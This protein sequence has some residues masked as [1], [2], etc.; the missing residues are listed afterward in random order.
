M[1]VSAIISEYN[2]FH[3]GHAYHIEETRKSGATHIVAIMS[4]NFVQRGDFAIISKHE[5]VKMALSSGVDLVI[6]IPVVWSI[7]S[8]EFFASAAVKIA[9]SL[10]LVDTLSFGSEIADINALKEA[11]EILNK[12][13]IKLTISKELKKGISYPK[14]RENVVKYKFGNEL[15]NILK[16]PNNILAI[17]YIKSLN[18]IKSNIKP[19][20]IKRFG[21]NH[22]EK[23]SNGCFSSAS[24]LRQLIYNNENYSSLVPKAVFK[25]INENIKSQKAP[26]NIYSM[27]TAILA[28]L[29]TMEKNELKNICDV[30]EGLENRIFNSIKL[31]T[32]L[33]ELYFLIKTKRYTLSRIQRII[34]CAFLG[35]TKADLHSSPPYIRVLGFNNN[36][37]QLLKKLKSNSKLPIIFKKS[38]INSLDNHAQRIFNSEQV[39]S[40]LYNLS[41]PH[42]QKCG[43]DISQKI[44]I[45]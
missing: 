32:S 5:R 41:T 31:S 22:D 25:I 42:I 30:S 44:V 1:N 12:N 15:S 9:D 3:N 7:A 27:Q 10:G 21:T 45:I 24:Y 13:D 19:L 33:D 39:A 8:A 36:G 29:R 43:L 6:E 2:P 26:A 17:E 20:A 37:K 23:Y 18:K 34:L 14:A 11:A 35:I 16:S 4:G 38:D 28:K 40:D